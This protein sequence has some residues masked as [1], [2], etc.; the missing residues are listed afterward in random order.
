MFDCW[1]IILPMTGRDIIKLGFYFYEKDEVIK[2]C[3]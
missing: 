3:K 2:I 1:Q